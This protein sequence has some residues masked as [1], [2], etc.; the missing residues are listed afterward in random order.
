MKPEF[1]P[2]FIHR[3]V[4]IADGRPLIFKLHPLENTRRAI[5]EINR[6]ATR[7]ESVLARGRERNDVERTNSHYAMV[8]LHLRGHG[9]GKRSF[10]GPENG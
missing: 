3:C 8:E 6:Y 1:R 10:L 2:L 9:I 4:E 7:R 5:R